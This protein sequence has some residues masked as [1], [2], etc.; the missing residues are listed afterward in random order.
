LTRR[1]L[2]LRRVE[3]PDRPDCPERPGLSEPPEP[4]QPSLLEFCRATTPIWELT[5]DG[6]LL[7]VSGTERLYGPGLDGAEQL[8]RLARGNE[9]DD[10][11]VG[12]MAPTVL[13]AR[14][15]SRL[16]ARFGPGVLAVGP[17]NVETFLARFPVT[18][19]PART[20][21]IARLQ[22][23][24]VRTFGDL[25]V[26]P[27]PLLKAVFGD[28]G[29]TL[30]DEAAGRRGRPLRGS[31]GKDR[32]TASGLELVAGVRLSRPLA[33]RSGLVALRKGL[34]L[35][36][37]AL[38]PDEGNRRGT[39]RLSALRP[40]GGRDT[41]YARGPGGA[42]WT[43]WTG[44]LDLLWD[45]LPHRR[46][47][48]MGAELHATPRRSGGP[49]QGSLFP[50]DQKDRR[51][52]LALAGIRRSGPGGVAVAGEELL[53]SWGARWYGPGEDISRKG[54]G[55]VDGRGP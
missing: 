4:G 19:L 32:E 35:R 37:L 47:G 36:A 28:R 14:L 5:R 49:H 40:G 23:L 24:G 9:S 26:V 29:P 1:I 50:E 8:C 30:A 41:A 27:R 55:L 21:E 54:R 6:A 52:A 44:L 20:N 3:R 16:A 43:V 13:A 51:L 45:R 10:S 53:V 42:G 22:E 2:H 11:W 25:Q 46:T 48:L 7:D 39:W 17:G 33:S 18:W 12:G 34:A 38:H 15:A 31:E